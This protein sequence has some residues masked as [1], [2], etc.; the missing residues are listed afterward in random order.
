MS[1]ILRSA[2]PRSAFSRRALTLGWALVLDRLTPEPPNRW[3]PVAWFGSFMT[4]FE[5]QIWAD[6]RTN[7]TLYTTVGFGLGALAGVAVRSST[8]GLTV[9]LGAQSLRKVA[10]EV[11]GSL[12]AG[13]IEKA[14]QILPSLVG[15]DPSGLDESGIAAAV[16]ES[17]AENTVDAV[18]APMFWT[19]VAGAPGAFGY[20]AI[21]TM[22]AMVGHHNQR[23]ERFGWASARL[24]DIANWIPARLFGWLVVLAAPQRRTAIRRAIDEDAPDHPSPNAGIAE[25]A[26]A[27]ALGVELGG[28][29]RYGE[30][31]EHRPLLGK[32]PRPTAS[33]IDETVQLVDRAQTIFAAMMIVPV[34]I[35]WG[36]G[37]SHRLVTASAAE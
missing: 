8:A 2:L 3:H 25:S 15:R 4:R 6:R 10:T 32:G 24:D 1:A 35:R 36:V 30:R 31:I 19:A 17:V 29:L 14:R 7:G 27:G 16:V 37:R 18:I 23:F 26:V 9:A 28:T 12:A 33:T 5:Q 21:N 34:L 13:E 11:E 20:R 22:D